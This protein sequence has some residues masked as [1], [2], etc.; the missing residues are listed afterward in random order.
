M[1]VVIFGATRM[2]GQGV[3][4]T[5]LDASDVESVLAV[6]R[7]PT[8]VTHPKLRELVRGNSHEIGSISAESHGVDARL[9]CVRITS[10]AM[11]E[12]EYRRITVE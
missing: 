1:K 9:Y 11:S 2:V 4:P 3:L 10:A 6:V 7:T 8:G 5:A 12:A